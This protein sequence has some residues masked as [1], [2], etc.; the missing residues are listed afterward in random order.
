MS[1]A[2][3]FSPESNSLL[4]K[5]L[6]DPKKDGETVLRQARL[7]H[8]IMS[9]AA[10]GIFLVSLIVTVCF[11]PGLPAETGVHFIGLAYMPGTHSFS[12]ELHR[13]LYEYQEIDVVSG[14]AWLFYP[15][16][17]TGVMLLAGLLLPRLAGKVK[18]KSLSESARM[19]LTEALQL[20]LDLAGLVFALYFCGI[21]TVQ[22]LRQQ[23]MRVLFTR[24]YL[25]LVLLAFLDLIFFTVMISADER[26]KRQQKK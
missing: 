4:Y 24:L 16:G 26:K 1:R 18:A 6:A 7:I 20:T 15:Y 3:L 9:T 22:I 23:P 19:K 10:R 21:W 13:T 2:K 17:V 12:E 25:V 11:Y 5:L 8:R 14:K